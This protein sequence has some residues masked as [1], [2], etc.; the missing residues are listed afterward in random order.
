MHSGQFGRIFRAEMP[1]P[2]AI[3]NFNVIYVVPFPSHIPIDPRHPEPFAFKIDRPVVG[4]PE[5]DMG[6]CHPHFPGPFQTRPN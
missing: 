2:I 3:R 4:R 5:H 6:R 1:D